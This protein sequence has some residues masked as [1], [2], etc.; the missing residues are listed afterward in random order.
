MSMPAMPVAAAPGCESLTVMFDGA[1]PLCRREVGVYQG[2]DSL[3]PV[4]WLD[5]SQAS[6]SMTPEDRARYLAR[7]HVRKRSG[8]LLSGAAAFVA[9]WQTMPG[10]RWLGR[11]GALP[12]V[13]PVLELLYRGFLRLRPVLQRLVRAA[14][15]AHLPADLIGD[16]RSDHAGETGAVWIYKGMLCVSRDAKVREFALHHL[17][18]ESRHLQLI[19]SLLPPLRR[20]WLLIPWRAA[21]FVTG[22]LPA[23]FGRQAV[24]GTIEAVE[25]FVDQHY[26]HQ[27]DAL[28]G[29]AKHAALRQVLIDCQQDERAHRDEAAGH[30]TDRSGKLLGWWCAAVGHGSA[31]AVVLARKV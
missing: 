11:L 6:V 21:G 24:F 7:F 13:T 4:A 5:V 30:L 25:T 27:I 9:L 12:G 17:A 29:R 19:S 1:C 26:Q 28:S 16:L 18:T 31:F 23:L 22:A 2:L 14:D 20:S 15:T 8:Q 3:E 10:W